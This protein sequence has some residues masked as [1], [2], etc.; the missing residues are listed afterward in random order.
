MKKS[1]KYNHII[2]ETPKEGVE[3]IISI[4][5]GHL[6]KVA[7]DYISHYLSAKRMAPPFRRDSVE[8]LSAS[9]GFSGAALLP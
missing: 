3:V 2:L 9:S 5:L 6:L 8:V 4:K 1:T 7:K